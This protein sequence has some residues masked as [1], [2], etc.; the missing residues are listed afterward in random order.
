VL[1]LIYHNGIAAGIFWSIFATWVVVELLGNRWQAGK[2]YDMR[3]LIVTLFVA[4]VGFMVCF[5]LP[6]FLPGATLGHAQFCFLGGMVLLIL[7]IALRQ[8]AVR[9]LGKYFT[10]TVSIQ[11]NH[12]IVEHGPYRWIRHPSYTGVLL[13][14]CGVGVILTNWAS[15]LILVISLLASILYRI[16]IEERTLLASVGPAY[17]AYMQRTTKRLIPLVY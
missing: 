7:G 12:Q 6:F 17:E 15:L 8:Y 16:P 1:P 4:C 13:A 5:L 3:S 14:I 11:E 9:T 10:L 2:S